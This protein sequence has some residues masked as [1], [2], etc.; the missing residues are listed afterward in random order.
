MI[1]SQ[2]LNAMKEMLYYTVVAVCLVTTPTL[3]VG[4]IISIFQAATQIN[5]VT[6]TFVPKMIVMFTVLFL[7]GPWLIQ[8]LIHIA[9]HYYSNLNIYIR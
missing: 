3:I 6:I 9:D 4:L 8:N 7:F 5:E 2:L 1:D